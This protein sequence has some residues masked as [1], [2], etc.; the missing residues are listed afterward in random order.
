MIGLAHALVLA[1][2]LSRNGHCDGS[3]VQ[4]GMN[5]PINAAGPAHEVARIVPLRA[6]SGQ[7]VAWLFSTR[8]PQDYLEIHYR[9]TGSTR[10]P[11]PTLTG[12][13]GSAW[14]TRTIRYPDFVLLDKRLSV[15]LNRSIAKAELY[16]GHCLSRRAPLPS[17][18][19]G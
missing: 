14:N 1:V 2:A 6:R 8:Q 12:V 3:M 7:I 17:E 5:V 18:I 9:K 11:D 10:T 4:V 15:R 16:L 19:Q 13:L